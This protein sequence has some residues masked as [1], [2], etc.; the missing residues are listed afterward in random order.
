MEAIGPKQ[1]F[2]NPKIQPLDLL[3]FDGRIFAAAQLLYRV[4]AFYCN[5]RE[6]GKLRK[7][8]LS[9]AIQVEHIITKKLSNSGL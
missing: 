7:R 4:S 6:F 3:I 9:P 2:G 1:R 5:P 8:V